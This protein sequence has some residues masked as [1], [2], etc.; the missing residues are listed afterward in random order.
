MSWS[1]EHA[2]D[3]SNRAW[4]GSYLQPM[5]DISVHGRHK[6][7]VLWRG[8][9]SR[10]PSIPA[11]SRLGLCSKR[12]GLELAGSLKPYRPTCRA[13]EGVSWLENPRLKAACCTL[14]P[15]SLYLP[16]L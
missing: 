7:L 13:V 15:M 4:A 11:H 10:R 2:Q 8:D 16:L 9:H 3:A 5:G 6:G 1:G 14:M 12:M